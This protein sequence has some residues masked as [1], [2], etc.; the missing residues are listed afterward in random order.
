MRGILRTH[1]HRFS[2]KSL[3]FP[4]HPSLSPTQ[5]SDSS[6]SSQSSSETRSTRSARSARSTRSADHF[7]ILSYDDPSLAKATKRSRHIYERDIHEHIWPVLQGLFSWHI[8][9]QPRHGDP[10]AFE[11]GKGAVDTY[12][13]NEN[14][15]A[16]GLAPVVAFMT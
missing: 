5:H 8:S 12:K 14:E 9:C 1:N 13:T 4:R 3:I 6:L 16:T 10:I 15:S 7:L 11:S 2:L